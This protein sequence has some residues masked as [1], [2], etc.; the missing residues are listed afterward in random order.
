M[1]NLLTREGFRAETAGDSEA[2]HAVMARFSPDLII[3]DLMLPGVDG[4]SICRDLRKRCDL[5]ILML[6]AK[7]EGYRPSARPGNGRGRLSDQAVQS[8]RTVGAGAGD[9]AAHPR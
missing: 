6:T 9:L 5:P 7:S 3:L 2:M 4:L 8:A 1:Q